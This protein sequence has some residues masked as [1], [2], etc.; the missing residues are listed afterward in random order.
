M[1]ELVYGKLLLCFTTERGINLPLYYRYLKK[2]SM[3][4]IQ[5]TFRLVFYIRD[6]RLGKG[7]KRLGILGLKWLFFSYPKEFMYT[8]HLI[9][10]Y[11]RWDD[12][13]YMWPKV[14]NLK[15]PV[16]MSEQEWVEYLQN[17]FC[18]TIE[19]LTQLRKN[20]RDIVRFFGQ[21]LIDDLKTKKP[22]LST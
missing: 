7:E 9:P 21:K 5:D 10:F 17:E 12:F 6:C 16:T 13:L 20:Q 22:S 2:A 19:D 15:T 3:E 14:L 18:T 1:T 11:G 8:K 4:N